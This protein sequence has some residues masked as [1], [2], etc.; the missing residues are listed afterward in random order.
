[1]NAD[2]PGW[3]TTDHVSVLLT[4]V[5]TVAVVAGVI[6]AVYKLRGLARTNELSA[7]ATQQAAESA[8]REAAALKMQAITRAQ[9]VIASPRLLELRSRLLRPSADP[10]L[11]EEE[12]H[13]VARAFDR[14]AFLI[15]HDLL[16]RDYA[17][18]LWTATFRR[19]WA[20]LEP[21][22]RE[23]IEHTD[24]QFVHNLRQLVQTLPSR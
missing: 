21:R 4:G 17:L 6:F 18:D 10:P 8:K 20:A 19:I 7:I 11:T 2:A 13:D 1:M 22:L 3:W 24:A 12:V 14:V 5:Q 16:E 15:N 23:Y 9:D